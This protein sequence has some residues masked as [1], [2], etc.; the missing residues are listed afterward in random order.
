MLFQLLLLFKVEG[1]LSLEVR[2]YLSK[3]LNFRFKKVARL[4]R[5]NW[6]QDNNSQSTIS[7]FFPFLKK[8][9]R[10]NLFLKKAKKKLNLK[11]NILTSQLIN[12]RDTGIELLIKR[13]N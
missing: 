4:F 7:I 6:S 11:I 5:M 9:T 1:Y 3:A 10:K 13:R 8:A 2:A 12:R